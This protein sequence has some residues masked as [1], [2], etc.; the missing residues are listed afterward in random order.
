[1][2]DY[3]SN[4]NLKSLYLRWAVEDLVNILKA[5]ELVSSTSRGSTLDFIQTMVKAKDELVA[6]NELFTEASELIK[7]IRG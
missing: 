1:M 6:N 7:L 5:I 4:P 2:L 3:T